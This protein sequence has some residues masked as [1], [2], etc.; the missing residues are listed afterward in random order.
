MQVAA[1]RLT[2]VARYHLQLQR[3]CVLLLMLLGTV[4]LMGVI[5]IVK[6]MGVV[7][8]QQLSSVELGEWHCWG[9]I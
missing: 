6:L 8:V 3:L 1:E 4:V 9:V 2:P 5:V 7:G